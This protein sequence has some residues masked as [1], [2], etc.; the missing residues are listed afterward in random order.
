MRASRTN[1][2]AGSVLEKFSNHT[3][4]NRTASLESDIN[5]C[6]P[7]NPASLQPMTLH[8]PNE[9]LGVRRLGFPDS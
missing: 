8:P 9:A 6:P 1:V 2:A 5:R 7:R 3:I 4:Q